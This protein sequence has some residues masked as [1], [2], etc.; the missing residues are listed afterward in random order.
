M[1]NLFVLSA[2]KSTTFIWNM[3]VFEQENVKYFNFLVDL[4]RSTA[5]R[6]NKDFAFVRKKQ[7][8]CRVNENIFAH[9][10]K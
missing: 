7:Y 2:H 10:P 1:Y 3:Q 8:L 9:V 4:E 6:T 5:K